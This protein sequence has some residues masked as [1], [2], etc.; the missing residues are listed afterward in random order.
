M[1]DQ[2]VY[3]R[4]T[5]I[6]STFFALLISLFLQVP[7][8]SAVPSY[9]RQ[10]GF[11]CK[12]CHYMPPELTPL[13][14]AFKLNGYTMAGQPTVLSKGTKR[15][16]GLEVLESFP[17]SV[18]FDTSFSS[19]KSPQPGTQ[20][21]NFQFPQDTSLF[22][23]G[24]WAPHVGS[25]VQVTYDSQSDHFTWDNTDIRYANHGG[26]LLGKPITYGITLNNNPGVEDLW[27]STPA[28]GYPFVGSNSAPRPSAGALINGG[29]AQDVAGV[30]GYTMWNEHWYLAS[31][32]YRS[33]HIG[34]TE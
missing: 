25:F 28:W 33:E 29:L 18:I 30:G 5:I 32:M 23:A 14:R 2:T 20:N 7:T 26:K 12:S 24:A 15:E 8:A 9:A 21:G 31:T 19:T 11:P 27:N 22:L 17:L 4:S 16:G 1:S 34:G 13:G 10:T 3:L 6:I